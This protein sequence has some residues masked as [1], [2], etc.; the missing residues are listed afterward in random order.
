VYDL[1]GSDKE[2]HPVVTI[3]SILETEMGFK[4]HLL[5]C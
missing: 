2:L 3:I 5:G 1:K 4:L